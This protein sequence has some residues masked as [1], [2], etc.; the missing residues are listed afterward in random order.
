[1]PGASIGSQQEKNMNR[2]SDSALSILAFMLLALLAAGSASAQVQ[3]TAADPSSATQGT[4]SLDVTISGSGFD[5]TAQVQFLLTGTENPGGIVVRKVAVRSAKRLVATIDV[6]DT[7]VIDRFDIV[8]TLSSGRKGKGTTLFTVLRKT[9]DP[10]AVDGLDFPAFAFARASGTTQEI[11]VSDATG[12]CVRP[13]LLVTDGYSA[14]HLAFSYPV[15]GTTDR[16][17]VIWWEGSVIVGADFTVA[18]TNV[19]VS[20]RRVF[21]ADLPSGTCCALD[22]S[23]DG[24]YIFASSSGGTLARIAVA[25]TTSRAVIKTLDDD[26][27]F[28]NVSVNGDGSS[29]Y[30]EERRMANNQPGAMQ[31]FRIDLAT[32]QSMLLIASNPTV[33]YP[34]AD[35]GSNRFGYTDYVA[36]SNNCYLLQIADG[37]TGATISYGQ[38]RYGKSPTWYRGKVLVEGYK[39]GKG[40]GLRCDF[41]GFVTE[42][43]PLTSAEKPLVRGWYPDGR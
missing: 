21:V 10:C 39:A 37:A 36:G 14:Q 18:G 41:T 17:R 38:P 12:T 28:N 19:A 16:G 35:P 11:A 15:D 42:V 20:N 22:L 29:L 24:S 3:V 13:L 43:D 23:P 27:W 33:I 32:L 1:V 25:D 31:L 40:G 34:A 2:V 9:N 7:A 30:V 5:S 8:V 26:G 4:T 6:A